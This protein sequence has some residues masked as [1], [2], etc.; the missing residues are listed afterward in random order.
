MSKIYIEFLQVKV[1]TLNP[2]KS[3]LIIY[4][5]LNMMNPGAIK[6]VAKTL[7]MELNDMVL[8]K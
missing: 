5:S 3:R 2:F 4:C 8:R 1:R 6:Q 7:L